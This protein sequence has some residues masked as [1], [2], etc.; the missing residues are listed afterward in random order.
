MTLKDKIAVVTGGASGIG[1]AVSERFAREGAV[2]VV[3][4]INAA[5]A[6]AFAATIANGEA[7]GVDVS[8]AA[9]VEDMFADIEA[10]HGRVDILVN[11]AGIME[12]APGETDRWNAQVEA[13]MTAMQRGAP[14]QDPWD[15]IR[16][17]SDDSWSRMIDIH[18]KGTFNC[19]KSALKR[20]SRGG[21]IINISSIGAVVGTPGV[22]H[23]SAA[24]AGICGF[25][26][27]M[28]TE[29]APK[30][31]RVNA[32]LPGPIE[33]PM[34]ETLSETMVQMFI[35]QIPMGR[36]GKAHEVANAVHFLASDE[37]SYFTG[38]QLS[39]NGGIWM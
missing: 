3:T 32:V 38:Q 31:I 19:T 11:S 8:D 25:T 39:P 27:A 29:V 20:M 10:R 1:A 18:L 22:P 14:L 12:G 7:A 26:R 17:V 4:D 36:R 15:F 30:G 23:Y 28:A 6:D 33:T 5:A 24:K 37:G 9:A 2:T 35:S 13:A 16:H 21:S 34:T